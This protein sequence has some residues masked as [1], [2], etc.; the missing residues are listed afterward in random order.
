MFTSRRE[1]LSDKVIIAIVELDMQKMWVRIVWSRKAITERMRE[2]EHRIGP[3]SGFDDRCDASAWSTQAAAVRIK[4]N[5]ST[6]PSL[7]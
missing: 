4:K 6:S 1:K 2:L 7:E 3:Y 5:S